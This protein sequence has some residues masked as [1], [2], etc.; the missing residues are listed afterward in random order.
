MDS[1]R[2]SKKNKHTDLSRLIDDYLKKNKHKL[3]KETCCICRL[4]F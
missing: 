2:I 1:I 4:S 3:G